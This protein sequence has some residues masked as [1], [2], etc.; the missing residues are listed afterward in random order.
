R[1]EVVGVVSTAA[2]TAKLSAEAGRAVATNSAATFADG[3]AVRVPVDEALAVYGPGCA[4][5]VA[6]DDDAIAAAVGHYLTDTH[7]LAEGAGAAP[8]AA[9]LTEG[10]RMRGRRVGLVLSGGNLE[11]AKLKQILGG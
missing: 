4:R 11:T 10:E 6:V 3:I 5:I 1:T 7:N 2:P 9:L 8:L